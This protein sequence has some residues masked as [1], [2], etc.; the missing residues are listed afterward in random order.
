[1]TGSL[2]TPYYITLNY[3]YDDP[4]ND[5]ATTID[6]TAIQGTGINGSLYFKIIEED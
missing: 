5:N 2:T 1:M 4:N 6:G 3:G